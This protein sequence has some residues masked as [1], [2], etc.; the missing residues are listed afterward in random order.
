M[1]QG[2]TLMKTII[3]KYGRD[4]DGVSSLHRRAGALGG[5]KSRGGGFGDRELAIRAGRLGGK[6]SRRGVAKLKDTTIN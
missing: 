2:E 4:E 1:S 3:A 6:K 5:K